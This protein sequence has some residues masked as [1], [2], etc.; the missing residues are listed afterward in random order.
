M[1]SP[2]EELMSFVIEKNQDNLALLYR[3]GY[4]DFTEDGSFDPE[5]EEQITCNCLEC[6]FNDE[7]CVHKKDIINY[8]FYFNKTTGKMQL[9][10]K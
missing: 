7:N 5:T 6:P 10:E 8:T 1:A 3:F 4:C 2:E 9:A